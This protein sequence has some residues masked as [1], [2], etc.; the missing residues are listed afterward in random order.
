VSNPNAEAISSPENFA[1]IDGGS[2][3]VEKVVKVNL[4]S[5]DDV[6]LEMSRVY[7]D[8]RTK[9]IDPQNGTRLVY[10]LSQL[11]KLR[12]ITQIARRSETLELTLSQR[13][14]Q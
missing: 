8:M 6:R 14:K 2:G 3:K 4:S 7:R 5:L 10:V 12:E 11:A 1:V 13:P 9:R